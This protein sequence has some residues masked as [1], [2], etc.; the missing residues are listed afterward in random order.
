MKIMCDP[1]PFGRA[2]VLARTGHHWLYPTLRR[3]GTASSTAG[4][5][6]RPGLQRSLCSPNTR[7][8]CGV[9]MS[10]GSG[11][12]TSTAGPRCI[13]TIATTAP[14][15]SGSH[16]RCITS[17]TAPTNGTRNVG[18]DAA[19]HA[20]RSDTRPQT[21]VQDPDR[22]LSNLLLIRGHDGA[23]PADLPPRFYRSAT[24]CGW[25][26]TVRCVRVFRR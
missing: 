7:C 6:T 11:R 4:P 19:G 12:S 2:A 14:A 18:V 13:T 26:A 16:A 3:I 8:V 17:E 25:V 23:V 22:E 1:I 5:T 24:G 21:A 20:G 15:I 10:C 9:V